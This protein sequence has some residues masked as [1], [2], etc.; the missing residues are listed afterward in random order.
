MAASPFPARRLL[1]SAPSRSIFDGSLSLGK[2]TVPTNSSFI[3][4]HNP[5]DF[6]LLHTLGLQL[7]DHS[8]FTIA[9]TITG[10][11]FKFALR[12]L[13]FLNKS[14]VGTKNDGIENG[15][16]EKLGSMVGSF[17]RYGEEV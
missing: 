12:I 5:S 6:T 13:H 2:A 16:Q 1:F 11:T 4:F 3:S 7:A 15:R 9:N 14:T 10:H 8:G 17:K